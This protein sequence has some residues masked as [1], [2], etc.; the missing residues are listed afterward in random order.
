MAYVKHRLTNSTE[1]HLQQ[2]TGDFFSGKELFV[3]QGLRNLKFR[4]MCDIQCSKFNWTTLS[5][6]L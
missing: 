4:F 2:R 6:S 5:Q 3:Y 1:L